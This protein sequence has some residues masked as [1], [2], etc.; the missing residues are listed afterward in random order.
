[1]T[2]LKE[3]IT[4]TMIEKLNESKYDTDF[5]KIEWLG[6]YDIENAS[7]SGNKLSLKIEDADDHEVAI[8]YTF[9]KTPRGIAIEGQWSRETSSSNSRDDFGKTVKVMV[10]NLEAAVDL[11]SKSL[12]NRDVQKVISKLKTI[13]V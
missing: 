5:R 9:K 13:K 11:F 4:E 8:E 1:M 7:S 12:R 10:K 2:N 3:Y 6:N